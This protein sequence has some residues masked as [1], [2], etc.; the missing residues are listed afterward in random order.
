M[1]NNPGDVVDDSINGN[2][3]PSGG[4]VEADVLP[5]GMKHLAVDADSA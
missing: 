4:D 5:D 2:E 3:A 1:G